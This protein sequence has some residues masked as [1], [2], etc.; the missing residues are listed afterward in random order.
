MIAFDKLK[1]ISTLDSII[2]VDP[3]NFNMK[4][5]GGRTVSMTMSMKQP[6]Y[7]DIEINYEKGEVII[8]F[9]GKI[10]GERY[11]ELINLN[12]IRVC[13]QR[14]ND[15]GFCE[16]DIEKMMYAQVV[17]CDVTKDVPITNIPSLN[18]YIRGHIR[19]YQAYT[20]ELKRNGNL[21]IEK[22]VT[23]RDYKRRI[24]LYD[25]Q[26]EMMRR[27]GQDFKARYGLE[28]KYDGICRFEMN[29]NS[30]QAIRDTLG[31]TG[32]TLSEVLRSRQNPIEDFLD[33][34][35]QEDTTACVQDSWKTYWQTLV[36]EDCCFDLAKVEAKLR[37]YKGGGIAKAMRPFRELM[38][39]LPDG[40]ST[41]TKDKLL[42]LVRGKAFQ[43]N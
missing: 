10:L 43:C 23:G 12:T 19:N 16:I 39:A 2:V 21:I 3:A 26:A 22:N 30:Q 34:V 18:R 32:T 15:L 37:E 4:T 36:L 42:E 8:E 28:G 9:T 17:K 7:L 11:T 20:C 29:L 33:D 40:A 5:K 41:W 13:F 1:L 24:T 31:I 38:E 35:I 6:F 14:I 25:K 27:T